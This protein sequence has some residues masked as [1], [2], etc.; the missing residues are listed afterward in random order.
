MDIL[1]CLNLFGTVYEGSQKSVSYG[2][3]PLGYVLL[4][5]AVEFSELNT[6]MVAYTSILEL[7]DSRV[8]DATTLSLSRLHV[9]PQDIL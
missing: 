5:A 3:I 1:N 4:V 2:C 6:V 8:F 7:R 9:T